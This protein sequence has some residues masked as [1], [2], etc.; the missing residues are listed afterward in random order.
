MTNRNAACRANIA[1]ETLAAWRDQ[2]LPANEQARLGAHI[3]TCAACQ[4]ILRHL[5]EL[6]RTLQSQRIPNPDA[7]LWR[8]VQAR[9]QS[10]PA[11][12]RRSARVVW[13]SVGTLATLLVIVVLFAQVLGHVARG[14]TSQ[15]PTVTAR[16]TATTAP[17]IL[18]DTQA[19][20][21]YAVTHLELSGT[22]FIPEDVFPNGTM[23]V[24]LIAQNNAAQ[25]VALF[26]VQS[27]AI[28]VLYTAP[29]D[30]NTPLQIQTDGRFVAWTGGNVGEAAA[31]NG[32]EV[33]G[34]AD[35]QTGH[36]TILGETYNYLINTTLYMDHGVLI[37]ASPQV[38]NSLPQFRQTDMNT[39][40]TRAL[41]AML[42][43]ASI[44]G[45]SWPNLAFIQFSGKEGAVKYAVDVLNIL[46]SRAQTIKAMGFNRQHFSDAVPIFVF[47]GTSIFRL[48]TNGTAANGFTSY[49]SA[50]LQSVTGIDQ[51]DVPLQN[52]GPSFESTTL[53]DFSINA[54]VVAWSSQS[55][56][57]APQGGGVYVWDREQQ[58]MVQITTPAAVNGTLLFARGHAL[59]MAQDTLNGAFGYDVI[60]TSLLPITPPTGT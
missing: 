9:I 28:Q 43:G 35:A 12:V 1:A 24:G 26:N 36:V 7:R 20:G 16:P 47:Q 17:A 49:T 33:F 10:P 21:H 29:S 2:A 4:A 41:P 46:T 38:G 13:G 37:W 58:R 60:D 54:R 14:T 32:H 40:V 30:M 31:T 15:R 42:N 57:G 59:I 11:P 8:R 51:S 45:F 23:L 18:S 3:P 52:L 48:Q 44:I 39:G 27:Q 22:H 50:Q 55:Y 19:W 6:A 53:R 56:V 25:K 5:A 34:Y